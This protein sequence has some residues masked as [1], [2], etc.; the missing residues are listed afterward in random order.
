[1]LVTIDVE[2]IAKLASKYQESN[3]DLSYP[4]WAAFRDLYPEAGDIAHDILETNELVD[5]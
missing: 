5:D 4:F 1:M 2:A 3:E